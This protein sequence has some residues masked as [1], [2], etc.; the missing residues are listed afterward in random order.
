MPQ[1][2]A[3]RTVSYWRSKAAYFRACGS[4]KKHQMPESR[5]KA[6]PCNAHTPRAE[7]TRTGLAQIGHLQRKCLAI[8][9]PGRGATSRSATLGYHHQEVVA[10][11]ARERERSQTIIQATEV[12]TEGGE[13]LVHT[14]QIGRRQK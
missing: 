6:C 5:A 12:S 3:A 13:T 1:P 11:V 7:R 2:S 4:G 14:D 8:S 9:S 10:Q